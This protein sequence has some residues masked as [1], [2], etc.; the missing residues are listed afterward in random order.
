[1]INMVKPKNILPTHGEKSMM[2]AFN[3]LA[4][5]MGY[6]LHKNLHPLTNGQRIVL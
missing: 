2:N 4:T 3:S 5:E 1:M 6:K